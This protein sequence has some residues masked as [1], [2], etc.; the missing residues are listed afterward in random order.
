[1]ADRSRVEGR[2]VAGSL[3]LIFNVGEKVMSMARRENESWCEC[4][5]VV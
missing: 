4:G 3:T 2:T 1:M 5:S